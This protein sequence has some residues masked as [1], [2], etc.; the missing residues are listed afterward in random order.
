ML[1]V[2][3]AGSA[4]ARV[5]EGNVVERLRG[6]IGKVTATKDLE[7]CR[8]HTQS[9]L[10][11][12]QSLRTAIQEGNDALDKNSNSKPE[13]IQKLGA[14]KGVFGED[15]SFRGVKL[16]SGNGDAPIGKIREDL[17]LCIALAANKG[18]ES[19]RA[20]INALNNNSKSLLASCSFL[21][22]IFYG[23]AGLFSDTYFLGQAF[24]KF[25]K[26]AEQLTTVF[27]PNQRTDLNDSGLD[28]R[29]MGDGFTITLDRDIPTEL[30]KE[31]IAQLPHLRAPNPF[32]AEEGESKAVV[33]PPMDIIVRSG[34]LNDASSEKEGWIKFLEKVGSAP[35][36]SAQSEGGARFSNKLKISPRTMGS[37]IEIC[38]KLTHSGGECSEIIG[39][40]PENSNAE[41]IAAYA[42]RFVGF[43]S[44]LASCIAVAKRPK[45]DT[46]ALIKAMG[47]LFSPAGPPIK[48]MFNGDEVLIDK[49]C[50]CPSAAAGS[51]PTAAVSTT[52]HAASADLGDMFSSQELSLLDSLNTN[53][54]TAAG[55]AI[56]HFGHYEFLQHSIADAYVST[57]LQRFE[58]HLED[59]KA[60][61]AFLR[62][63]N[64]RG[65][66]NDS[67]L[68]SA[69]LRSLEEQEAKL[70]NCNSMDPEYAR[71]MNKMCAILRM[72]D[73]TDCPVEANA[74]KHIANINSTILNN[75]EVNIT[76]LTREE[77]IVFCKIAYFK[78]KLAEKSAEKPPIPVS[79]DGAGGAEN[80]DMLNFSVS[81][82]EKKW[83]AYLMTNPNYGFLE[84][85]NFKDA[86]RHLSVAAYF[87]N[88]M[89][90]KKSLTFIRSAAVKYM[91]EGS[92]CDALNELARK[93]D[94]NYSFSRENGFILDGD[95]N[96]IGKQKTE[97]PI[98][99]ELKIA[100]TSERIQSN[101]N[102][103]NRL[104]IDGCVSVDTKTGVVTRKDANGKNMTYVTP[105]KIKNVG[106]LLECSVAFRDEEGSL[107]FFQKRCLA[108]EICYAKLEG[109]SY[110]FLSP[111]TGAK[112][113]YVR[114]KRLG[115]NPRI[116]DNMS[117]SDNDNS[118]FASISNEDGKL[119]ERE[120]IWLNNSGTVLSLVP[121]VDGSKRMM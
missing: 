33:L 1:Q 116:A 5:G 115:D 16:F 20:V 49:E 52:S 8:T 113:Q 61:E 9:L 39:E 83:F 4:V 109:E 99:A 6:E 63:G 78:S 23:F 107:H 92:V 34:K 10:V 98:F 93:I 58:S 106:Y 89:Y 76:S 82:Q 90:E 97:P 32:G 119:I 7:E 101:K 64:A 51:Q 59:P 41:A 85:H 70:R 25:L 37:F 108:N 87:R 24:K 104:T 43:A 114:K 96:L 75:W 88:S 94:D 72:I 74:W 14:F 118:F 121:D 45:Q 19:Y 40:R 42:R 31:E 57:F 86:D 55:L 68:W 11:E 46:T 117:S 79:A 100:A 44:L 62:V 29:K 65:C 36:T 38:E 54:A 50:I 91:Q 112:L 27:A 69:I 17:R 12:I 105:S 22:R 3:G 80:P 53:D 111:K 95:R 110:I 35:K 28:F 48:A 66:L 15:F 2:P 56:K 73:V 84:F 81:N 77:A 103:G 71:V 18:S 120:R 47:Q 13:L 30:E 60:I 21:R 67:R 26:E 102:D